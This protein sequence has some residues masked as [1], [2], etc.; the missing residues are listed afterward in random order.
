MIVPFFLGGSHGAKIRFELQP[1]PE[2]NH[3]IGNEPIIPEVD[4]LQQPGTSRHEL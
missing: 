4:A 2:T 3:Q 1:I